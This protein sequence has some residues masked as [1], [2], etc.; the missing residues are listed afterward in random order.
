MIL[1][2]DLSNS[3]HE[4]QATKELINKYI[5]ENRNLIRELEISKNYKAQ[6]NQFAKEIINLNK[7]LLREKNLVINSIITFNLIRIKH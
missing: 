2:S 3:E 7:E 1:T 5:R 4:F 6:A